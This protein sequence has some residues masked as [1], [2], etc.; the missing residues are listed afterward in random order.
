VLADVYSRQDR[1]R[2]AEAEV[3]KARE[4]EATLRRRT[5]RT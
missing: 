1:P 3:T 5:P 4:L 2:E